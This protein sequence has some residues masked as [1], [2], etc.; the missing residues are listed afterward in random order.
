M[1]SKFPVLYDESM[2]TVLT[3]ELIRY[4]IELRPHC[5]SA[6]IRN[7]FNRLLVVV[8]SSLEDLRK[9]VRGLV[10]MSSELEEVFNSMLVGK[11]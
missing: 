9:A 11:V 6:L 1:T 8:R 4:A 2:N 7:R 5:T 3:Q 10:V